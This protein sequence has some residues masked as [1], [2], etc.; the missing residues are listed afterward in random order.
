MGRSFTNREKVLM[1]ILA[2]LLIGILYFKVLLEPVNDSIAQYEQ[3]TETEQTEIV[4][5]T[6]QVTKMKKMQEELT[7]LKKSGD[8]KPLPS[9]DNS[10]AMLVELNSILASASDYSLTFGS[11]ETLEEESY[12]LRRPV[13]LVFYA[14]S[15]QQAR[16]ILDALHNSDNV[17]QISDLTI[18]FKDDQSVAVTLSISFFELINE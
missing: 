12:I 18:T 2:V 8:A 5:N 10:D 9:Y 17:N 14:G 16:S 13:S 4:K 1:V 3:D 11:T 6:A 15:Y 7:E